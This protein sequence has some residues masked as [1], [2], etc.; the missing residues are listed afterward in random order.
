MLTNSTKNSLPVGPKIGLKRGDFGNEQNCL[1]KKSEWATTYTFNT[2]RM[3]KTRKMSKITSL[4]AFH[5][6][7]GCFW[8]FAENPERGL[9]LGGGVKIIKNMRGPREP[10]KAPREG[11][12][13]CV[14][15]SS[16]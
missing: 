4:K 11:P 5:N 2:C 16:G 7:G 1:K 13:M 6:F 15:P 12:P 9:I 10:T 3:G 8:S 14:N